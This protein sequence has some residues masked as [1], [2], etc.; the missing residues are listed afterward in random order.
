MRRPVDLMLAM[1][2]LVLPTAV[3]AQAEKKAVATVP[4]AA[5]E[6]K[7]VDLPAQ[8]WLVNCAKVAE[9][10]ACKATQALTVPETKQLLAAVAVYKAGSGSGHAMTLQLPHGLFLPAGVSVQ[11]DAEAAQLVVIESCDSRGCFATMPIPDK[12]LAA[13]RKGKVL[14]LTFQNLTKG[15]VKVQLP[16]SGFPDALAKL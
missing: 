16:L 11:I 9:V 13:M 1:T 2:L 14:G 8:G 15:N 7:N 4:N 3:L 6:P 5:A 10:M 12:A